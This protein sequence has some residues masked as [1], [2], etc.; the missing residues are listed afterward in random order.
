MN[1]R[2][3]P[4][5]QGVILVMSLVLLVDGIVMQ[6]LIP[7]LLGLIFLIISIIGWVARKKGKSGEIEK[8]GGK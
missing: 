8:S 2:S 5:A 6:N 4:V 7:L 3:L 1:V